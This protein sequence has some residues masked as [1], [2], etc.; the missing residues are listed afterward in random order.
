MDVKQTPR[1]GGD[2]NRFSAALGMGS[3]DSSQA[4]MS[5]NFLTKLT[6]IG[7]FA[8][9]W[10]ERPELDANKLNDFALLPV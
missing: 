4:L 8:C 6:L 10:K 1:L 5:Q 2:P 9:S 7:R 3:L